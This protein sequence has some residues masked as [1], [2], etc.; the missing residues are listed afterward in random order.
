MTKTLQQTLYITPS[1]SQADEIKKRYSENYSFLQVKT[2]SQI[3]ADIFEIYDDVHVEIDA[4]IGSKIIYS[5][6]EDNRIEYFNYIQEGSETLEVLYD[7]FIKL[8]VNDVSIDKFTYKDEKKSALQGLFDAYKKY[9]KEHNLFDSSDML[10]FALERV[11]NYLEN[12][13]KVLLE[14]FDIDNITLIKSKK[15]QELLEKIAQYQSVKTIQRDANQTD[16]TLYQNFA[17]NS[18]DEVRTAIKIAKQLMLDGAK[19]NEIAIITSDFSEYAPYF[20][21][22]LD[23]YSMLGY[24]T[25]GFSL[26]TIS[27][28]EY[29]LKNHPNFMVQKGYARYLERLM[30]LQTYFERLQLPYNEDKLKESLLKQTKY[31]KVKE[32]IL[33]S[34]NNKLLGVQKDFKHIIFIGADITHFP[35]KQQKNFLYTEEQ[36]KQF[37]MHNSVYD[38]SVTLYNT[39]KRLSEN[40]YIITA[41]YSGKRKLAPSIVLDKNID[42]PFEIRDELKSRAEILRERKQILEEKPKELEL[43]QQSVISEDF[44]KYDGNIT[45]EFAQAKKLSAS[46]LNTYI[47]CP[48]QYY[49]SDILQLKAPQDDQVGFDPAGRGTLMHEC[50]ELFVKEAKKQGD[51]LKKSK[52]ELYKIMKQCSIDAYRSEKIQNEMGEENIYH[53]IDIEIFQKGLDNI[54]SKNKGE[55]AKFVDYFCEN[56]FEGFVHSN[57]EELFMLDT[58][59]K[60]IDLNELDPNKEEDR[61]KIKKIDAQKRF[62][63]GFIDRLD[64]LENGVNIIDYKSS[65]NSK[66]IKDFKKESLKDFQLGIYLLYVTQKYPDK[67]NYNAHLLSFKEKDCVNGRYYNDT[68]IAI[69]NK[70]IEFDEEYKAVLIQKIKD[71]SKS[72]EDGNLAFNSEDEKNCEWCNYRHICHQAV[73]NKRAKEEEVKD[74][75]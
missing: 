57:P 38:S 43:F 5:C 53:K 58:D 29:T 25:T 37:F 47:K 39:L 55:L 49:F 69:P 24:D 35:P 62:I 74:A 72:I 42:N 66:N 75:K 6:I 64:N 14:A 54:E 9:K 16:T 70:K 56:G 19:E 18:Y 73:L 7:F 34:E 44:T 50:F 27:N 52:S 65:L 63:K 51:F 31:R 26:F 1:S 8:S 45:G 41:T 61:E 15:E 2:L 67:Q 28:N 13:N 32:G 11:E 60:P 12:F 4:V 21:S 48:M 22:L 46:A 71:I 3:V 68:K 36:A 59:F 17:F 10:L 23:E 40:L 33:F 30:Q 20:Y